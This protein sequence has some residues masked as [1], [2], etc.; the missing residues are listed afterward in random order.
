[1]SKTLEVNGKFY[2]VGKHYW[3]YDHA[4]ECGVTDVLYSS[5]TYGFD[6]FECSGNSWKNCVTIEEAYDNGWLNAG[7]IIDSEPQSG[8]W[9]IVETPAGMRMPMLCGDDG[10][11]DKEV[12][13]IKKVEL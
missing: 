13:A 2:E 1:M 6:N 5:K 10:F 3:F 4:P 7:T 12:K 9:W 8:E 11:S